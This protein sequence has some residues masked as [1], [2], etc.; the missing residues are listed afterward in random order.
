MA[1]REKHEKTG[2]AE[3]G[4]FLPGHSGNPNGRPPGLDF[5]AVC[6]SVAESEGIPLET[7]VSRVFKNLMSVSDSRS[8][9]SVEAGREILNR[10]CGPVKQ[11]MTHEGGLVIEVVTGVNRS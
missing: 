1:R 5:R 7:V 11:E 2:R 6:E 4:K 8:K 3:D 9:G 10:L